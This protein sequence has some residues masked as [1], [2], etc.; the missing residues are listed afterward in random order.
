MLLDGNFNSVGSKFFAMFNCIIILF[1]GSCA[2][3][4][5]LGGNFSVFTV[6]IH[7][8]FLAC[9]LITDAVFGKFLFNKRVY[10]S[11]LQL[12]WA[13][14]KLAH[15]AFTAKKCIDHNRVRNHFFN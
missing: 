6:N 2:V 8:V 11:R 7:R 12:H 10:L 9:F 13:G 14:I 15:T 5:T 3:C 4:G 1:S